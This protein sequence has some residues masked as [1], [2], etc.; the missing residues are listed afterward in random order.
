MP[1]HLIVIRSAATDYDLQERIRGTLDLPLAAEGISAAMR[2]GERLAADPPQALYAST[3]ECAAETARL[4][5]LACGIKPRQVANLGNLDLGLWQGKLVD[6][7]REKQPRLYRQWQDNPWSVAPPEG[8]LLEEACERAETVVEKLFK[9][10]PAGRIA[11]VVPQPLDAI[12]RW[13]VSG[14]SMG[15]L[16][17]FDLAAD[18][19]DQLPVAAQWQPSRPGVP[20]APPTGASAS[21]PFV[22]R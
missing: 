3:D 17:S 16:W 14:R 22:S 10:H 21:H 6:E 9:R 20:L 15:D 8:E 18:L 19:I 11:L 13:L 1:D 7:I 2:A 5:G 4:V 12:V